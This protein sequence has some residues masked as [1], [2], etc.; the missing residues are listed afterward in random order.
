LDS[1]RGEKSH[2]WPVFLPDGL[3]ILYLAQTDEGGASTD[4]SS[5]EALSLNDGRR[6]R[7]LEANSS[8]AYSPS[9]SLV[10][11]RAGSL[12]AQSF[13]SRQLVVE[14]E[15]VQVAED[16]SYTQNERAIFTISED[17][18]LV[19]LEGSGVSEPVSLEWRNRDGEL[20]SEAAPPGVYREIA[21]APNSR[22]AVF[23]EGLTVWV[24]DLI[25]GT[26][27]RVTDDDED[28]LGPVWSPD[29]SWLAFSTNRT[30]GSEIRKKLASGLGDEELVVEL[31]SIGLVRAWS[32]D[33]KYL[34]YEALGSATEWDC[35]LYSFEED[36]IRPVVMTRYSDIDPAFSPDSRW[37][38][39]ASNES[40][41]VEIYVIP[42]DDQSRKWQVSTDGGRLPVWNP[43]GDEIF[44]TDSENR[45]MAV[46]VR[47]STDLEIGK[48]RILFEFPKQP[49][50][51]GA[52]DHATYGVAADG[53]TFL[54]QH[55]QTK[56][57]LFDSLV[58]I[59]GWN[60]I[61]HGGDS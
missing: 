15:P 49:T 50:P 32:P 56:G 10:F 40:G 47:G 20:L 55:S 12:Y 22:E 26:E 18:S 44:Y 46:D 60:E 52:Y 48:A 59:Q 35:W 45:M 54:V 37:L 61:S 14:G 41:R 43:E 6:T 8:V 27:T 30:A 24:R 13:D 4:H 42:V 9:G 23:T 17:G 38:A 28:H 5:I 2:R 51:Y 1:E 21:L 36:E 7:I 58:L 31:E 53:R 16:V 11:W 19:Y 29:G 33:G 3:T 57:R 34:A 39:Y 25:R